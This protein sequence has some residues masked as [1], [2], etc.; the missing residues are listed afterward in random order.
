MLRAVKVY[1]KR[2][3]IE[4]SFSYQHNYCKIK[5]SETQLSSAGQ[6]CMQWLT[7]ST[8]ASFVPE[9]RH[10]I[11]CSLHMQSVS[12]NMSVAVC[13]SEAEWF[14]SFFLEFNHDNFVSKFCVFLAIIMLYHHHH[15]YYNNFSRLIPLEDKGFLI[16]CLPKMVFNHLRPPISYDNDKCAIKGPFTL[17]RTFSLFTTREPLLF[18]PP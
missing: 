8:I 7:T 13:S 9:T 1:L 17:R 14:Y 6:V 15:H 2:C 12:Y 4:S 16:E 11:L 18:S 10:R 3:S 5:R